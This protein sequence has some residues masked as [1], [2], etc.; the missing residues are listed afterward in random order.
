MK[1]HDGDQLI[2]CQ[3]GLESSGFARKAYEWT[4]RLAAIGTAA[5]QIKAGNLT[6][7]ARPLWWTG[8]ATMF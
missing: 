7:T 2:I 8:D 4:T 1:E 6:T 5:E 3:D